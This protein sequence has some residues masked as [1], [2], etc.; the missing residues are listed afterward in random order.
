MSS[1]KTTENVLVKQLITGTNQHFSGVGSLTFGGTTYALSALTQL[2][3]S[4]VDL[5]DGVTAA[6]NALKAKL[7]AERAKVAPLRIVITA[8]KAF[9]LA[10]FG[11]QPDVLADFGLAPRKVPTKT[12]EAVKAEA[13]LKRD[14][15]RAARHTTGKRKKLAIK[16]SLGAP[17]PG[18][19]AP[20]APANPSAPTAAPAAAPKVQGPNGQ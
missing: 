20:T 9:I 1:N 12:P 16:G 6:K 8:Y 10:Y 14:A 4:F 7:E 13:V 5:S 11:R 15:T 2:L 19:P 17:P 3:Q 18:G